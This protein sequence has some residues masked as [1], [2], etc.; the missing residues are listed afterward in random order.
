M[1]LEYSEQQIVGLVHNRSVSYFEQCLTFGD[2]L[3]QE[4]RRA[5]YKYLL[6][7][8]KDFYKVQAKTLLAEGRVSRIIAN[9]EAIYS[10]KIPKSL[11]QL[12][13]CKVRFFNRCPSN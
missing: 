13:A 10:V 2:R 5:L 11:T 8:N 12:M 4:E 1:T 9:G 7:S 6:E 3:L